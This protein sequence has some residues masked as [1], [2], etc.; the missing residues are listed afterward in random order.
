MDKRKKWITCLLAAAAV[1]AVGALL[2][3]PLRD[4]S[5]E[6]LTVILSNRAV[7]QFLSATVENGNDSYTVAAKGN[8]FSC[9]ELEG[10]PVS[11]EAMQSFAMACCEVSAAGTVRDFFVRE[12]DYGLDEPRGTIKITYQDKTSLS[13]QI[14]SDVPDSDQCYLRIEGEKSI[15]IAEKSALSFFF[16]GK[17]QL[18]NMLLAPNAGDLQ[19]TAVPTGITYAAGDLSLSIVSLAQPY[20]D[21]YGN[22]YNWAF[23][24]GGYLDGEQY[25][26]FF[27]RCMQMKA[28]GVYSFSP[29]ESEMEECGLKAPACRLAIEYGNEKSTL[30]LGNKTGNNYYVYKEGVP[31]IFTVPEVYCSFEGVTRYQLE[32]R[33]LMAPKREKVASVMVNTYAGQEDAFLVDVNTEGGAVDGQKL[34]EY[35]F[36]GVYQLLCSLRAEYQLEEIVPYTETDSIKLVY[37]YKDGTRD[38]VELV[39]YGVKRYAVFLNKKAVCAVRSSYGEKVINTLSQISEGQKIDAEW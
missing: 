5:E 2:L 7:G 8:T 31:L 17:E 13:L 35:T 32:S 28:E 38:T 10:L 27:G 12:E 16:N 9:K 22:V 14:G 3:L 37:L 30:L 4:P 21:G 25:T 15:Y 34:S 39:P 29:S 20:T 24:D 11:Q 23:R 1:L 33:Y 6:N 19:E 26:A 36:S 18:L